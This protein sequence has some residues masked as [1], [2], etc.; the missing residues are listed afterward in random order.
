MLSMCE[1]SLRFTVSIFVT[2][3]ITEIG[4]KSTGLLHADDIHSVNRQS[5][6][7]YD[8]FVD[9]FDCRFSRLKSTEHVRRCRLSRKRD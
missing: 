1:L 8:D 2:E 9:D 5:L 6:C 7:H 4:M 3:S